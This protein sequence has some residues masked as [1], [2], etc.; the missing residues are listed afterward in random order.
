MTLFLYCVLEGNHEGVS[1]RYKTM[2]MHKRAGF[3]F[4]FYR[5]GSG[6][7]VMDSRQAN[8]ME[9]ALDMLLLLCSTVQ[10]EM[11]ETHGWKCKKPRRFDKVCTGKVKD[12]DLVN[13]DIVLSSLPQN[14][15]KCWLYMHSK[16]FC[17][18]IKLSFFLCY[19]V[20]S[21]KHVIVATWPQQ[22]NRCM[23]TSEGQFGFSM[24]IQ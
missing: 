11:V 15:F 4:F 16:R 24:R 7:F 1:K 6:L 9:E 10:V 22:K 12:K 14:T 13:L 18:L 19:V 17:R 8:W 21:R 3:F 20:V 5:F 2:E 23:F